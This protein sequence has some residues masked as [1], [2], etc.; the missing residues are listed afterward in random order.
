MSK[1]KV[2]KRPLAIF[3]SLFMVLSVFPFGTLTAFA[4]DGAA[5]DDWASLQ[6][7]FNEGGTVTLSGNV[8]APAGAAA[9][10]VPSR[11][12][13]TL[14]LNGCTI[15]RA[16]TEETE[17]GSVIIISGSLD[18]CG[19]GTITGGN[20][21]GSGGGIWVKRGGSVVL[22]EDV[23]VSG[24]HAKYTG[25]GV[26]V[27]GKNADFQ[28]MDGTS[29]TNNSAKNGGGLAQDS[30]GCLSVFSGSISNNTAANNGG[31]IWYGGGSGAALNLLGGEI[32]GNTAGNDGGGVYANR[33]AFNMEP[34]SS[35]TNNTAGH[36]GGGVFM[37]GDVFVPGGTVS[38]NTA[39]TDPEIGAKDANSI[40]SYTITIDGPIA[41]GTVTADKASAKYGETVTLTVTPASEN[42]VLGSLTVTGADGSTVALTENTFVM[43]P[44]DV[45]V[46]ASFREK[47]Q[48]RVD[49]REYDS[50]TDHGR[51]YLE[52]HFTSDFVYEGS[53]VTAFAD[54]DS[55]MIA[56]AWTVLMQDELSGEYIYAVP[57]VSR[58]TP[59]TISF[60]MP[61]ADVLISATF[62]ESHDQRLVFVSDMEGG[63]VITDKTL[64]GRQDDELVTLTIQPGNG[65][66]YVPDSLRLMD[67]DRDGTSQLDITNYMETVTE[68]SVYS[69]N[70]GN[71]DL[72]VYADF[73]KV[74]EQ[75]KHCV[76]VD[77]ETEN[78]SISA[79]YDLAEEGWTVKVTANPDAYRGYAVRSV[80]VTDEDGTDYP[81]SDLGYNQYSFTMPATD[82]FVT[83]EFGIPVY[84][85]TTD[86]PSAAV[87]GC[88]LETDAEAEVGDD[89][90]VWVTV[91]DEFLL[92]SLTVTGDSTSTDY[93][94][95]LD[96]HR[97]GSALYRYKFTMP[98]EPVT[99]S[100]VF[101]TMKYAL[102]V[103]E[104]VEGTVTFT[105][106]GE[107]V[108]EAAYG[109]NVNVTYVYENRTGTYEDIIDSV[110][111]AYTI[112]GHTARRPLNDLTITDGVCTGSFSMP[113]ADV[114]IGA[115]YV[116]PYTVSLTAVQDGS[117]DA[118]VN[119][120]P[121]F[122]TF[123]VY[124]DETVRLSA[125]SSLSDK[126]R[127]DWRVVYTDETGE[128]SVAVTR[129]SDREASFTM[130]EA[131]VTVSAELTP[132]GVPY[133]A[134][135]WN[136]A[137]AT[138]TEQIRY[139]AGEYTNLSSLSDDAMSDGWYVL[140][141]DRIFEN[142]IT[143]SGNV[144]LI[145]TDGMT[146]T[147]KKGI[148][149]SKDATLSIY[150]QTDDSGTL[151][152]TGSSGSAGIG[153]DEGGAHGSINVYGG[154][155]DATGGSHGAGIG[156]GE[157]AEG[158]CGA[159]CIFG[160][161]ITALGGEYGAGIGGGDESTGAQIVICGGDIHA[162]GGD[163]GAGIGGGCER[164]PSRVT[165]RGGK[166]DAKGGKYG[167][168]IGE[169]YDASSSTSSGTIE[170]RGCESIYATGGY[171]A[172][173]IGGGF[174]NN[175]KIKVYIYG[176]EDIYAYGSSDNDCGSAG[177]GAGAFSN[178]SGIQSGGGDFDGII[179][180]SGGTVNAVGSG[181][182]ASFSETNVGAAGL[183]AGYGGN[184]TGS[185]TVSGGA[186]RAVGTNGGAAIGAGAETWGTNYG[187]E[188]EG[189]VTITGGSLELHLV[190]NSGENK[191]LLIGHGCNGDTNG[192]LTLGPTMR[193]TG[194]DLR[195]VAAGDRVSTCRGSSI[196]LMI[197]EC[198]HENAT[199]QRNNEQTHMR[200]C[201]NCLFSEPEEH[202]FYEGA[203]DCGEVGYGVFFFDGGELLDARMSYGMGGTVEPPEDPEKTGLIFG[204]WYSYESAQNGE[205]YD[206][207]EPIYEDVYLTARWLAKFEVSVYDRTTQTF[208]V[209]GKVSVD[210]S[211]DLVT[212]EEILTDP[213][214]MIDLT[215]MK[216][217][218][219]DFVG[220]AHYESID[221]IYVRTAGFTT[222]ITKNE[223]LCAVFEEHV[224]TLR[225]V[226]GYE[227]ECEYNG[228]IDHYKCTKC[229]KYFSDEDGLN[230]L[231]EEDILIPAIH[232]DWDEPNY[233]WSEDYSELI[234]W[235]VCKNDGDHVDYE[236]VEVSSEV[237]KEPTCTEKGETT[238]TSSSFENEA[239][240]AQSITVADISARGHSYG[241]WTTV[242]PATCT[243][244]GL[245][246]RVCA[247]DESHKETRP[248]N[249][250]GHT[251]GAPV[252]NWTD[253]YK[254]AVTLTCVSGDDTQTPDVTV[255]NRVTVEPTATAEG[256][257]VYTATAE[258]NGQTYTDTK[259][260]ILPATGT[261][262]EPDPHTDP[263]QPSG[264]KRCK[265]CDQ[266]HT[267]FWGSIVGFFHAI[268]YFFAH[269][270][271]RG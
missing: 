170:I 27:S 167:A 228:E 39:P 246:Q 187:G 12:R 78:G 3:V 84:A 142:R 247:N 204:G 120:M 172:A 25:G 32:S 158:A 64:V 90:A 34:G 16:L 69:I 15:D 239:F 51:V 112:N 55:G 133:M 212:N 223:H 40:P 75:P 263:D 147:A 6:A 30:T 138:L 261:P 94:I 178:I 210:S 4:G 271:G 128:H 63:T 194:S 41:N 267:G 109:E 105:V 1:M 176:G 179:S 157:D 132:I 219:Y 234:A 236:I 168:G 139:Y 162:K 38:G 136:S 222:R 171:L 26:Y 123:R 104:A 58:P 102:T 188:C 192:E 68:N 169:G 54:P 244:A 217:D 125:I 8:T 241:E 181:T 121:C 92:Q 131:C 180:I 151:I 190:N 85:I 19:P 145:L 50:S 262:D 232:H 77:G 57:D 53:T 197:E 196:L 52:D 118:S 66:R 20:T 159:V 143:V 207:D 103:N 62:S 110:T 202:F 100:A 233:E 193:V 208:G 111:Y 24:N 270:F 160:G 243:E 99:V 153:G 86:C 144:R 264:E 88:E 93:P 71:N 56:A 113:S 250:T 29:I 42:Y 22:D 14:Y 265:W 67:V 31:G 108:T 36:C 2:T 164:G 175:T 149:V 140:D 11:T 184:M 130:P 255:T 141:G 18:V 13:V 215:A 106:G 60:P 249:A 237:T 161:G 96:Y 201:V 240:E 80:I 185:I 205:P 253:D 98:D 95:H 28:M 155:I 166:I 21:S 209:G 65:Y 146:L 122:A 45:T 211:E 177:I 10:T 235:R 17:N 116:S 254:A 229:G 206:F 183:G 200:N 43:P 44:K 115:S 137:N 226:Y 74:P 214:P 220:W 156:T 46:T 47:E 224:H 119:G 203:C 73:E 245:E 127:A 126:V 195:P 252:W 218:G 213:G 242:Q 83:A 9:L 269:L 191:A 152:V 129:I 33:S 266:V 257:R 238:Y 198:K 148:S 256:K 101:G 124:P 59:N 150:G 7:A 221:S 268:L 258:F 248:V 107:T 89:V 72:Y 135:G 230:E 117:I 114:E 251:Y 225:F 5:A 189:S 260:E 259:E 70:M 231:T 173:G 49:V 163:K 134:R 199:Y 76:V 37:G 186:V 182:Y 35:I 81:V 79:D 227:P 165:I 91:F 216:D 87:T 82:V 154:T 48:F 174:Y 23:T 61:S 97:E